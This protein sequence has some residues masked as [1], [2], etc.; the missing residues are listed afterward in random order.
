ME[1]APKTNA[2]SIVGNPIIPSGVQKYGARRTRL[3][4]AGIQ[5]T[6]GWLPHNTLNICI[7]NR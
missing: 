5:L 1:E 7:E 6:W 4:A 2:S 3:A